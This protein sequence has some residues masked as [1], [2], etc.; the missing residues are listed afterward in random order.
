MSTTSDLMAPTVPTPRVATG[1]VQ[2]IQFLRFVAAGMVLL[3]HVSFFIHHRVDPDVRVLADLSQGVAL[4]FVISG[5]IMTV[6]ASSRAGVRYFILSRFTRIVAPFRAINA[7]K[8]LGS[9]L[10]PGQIVKKPTG[11]NVLYSPLK[12]AESRIETFYE[13]ARSLSFKMAFYMLDTLF[14]LTHAMFGVFSV[15]SLRRLTPWMP[16]WLLFTLMGVPSLAVSAARLLFSERPVTRS[17]HKRL[18]KR[19]KTAKAPE[20]TCPR[21]GA[22]MTVGTT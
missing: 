8:R 2:T 7:A 15:V 22:C 13:V 3:A 16:S 1:G 9:F 18:L 10:M 14:A 12:D 4:F 11:S 6:T 20:A 19:G 21:H 17:Q 5:F